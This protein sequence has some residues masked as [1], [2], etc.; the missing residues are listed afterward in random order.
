MRP[1]LTW[2]ALALVACAGRAPRP[3][4]ALGALDAATLGLAEGAR[5]QVDVGGHVVE[6]EVRVVADLPRGLAAVTAGL[7]GQDWMDLPGWGRVRPVA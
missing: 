5:A 1:I 2:L 6:L 7:S 4:I 3:C